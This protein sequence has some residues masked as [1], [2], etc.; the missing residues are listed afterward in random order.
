[1]KTLIR[2]VP[3]CKTLKVAK[4]TPHLLERVNSSKSSI[5]FKFYQKVFVVLISL[6]TILIFPESPK[7]LEFLCKTYHTDQICNV[8]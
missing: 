7:N 6:S 2:P 8:W 1:M 5:E 4:I 3:K